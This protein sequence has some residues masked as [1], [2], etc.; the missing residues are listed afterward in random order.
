MKTLGL[1]LGSNSLG[2]AVLEDTTGD[3]LDKGVVIFPDGIDP[4]NDNGPLTTPAAQRR[5]VRQARR[6]KFR[7]KMRKWNLL[8]LLIANKMCPL[9]LAELEDWIHNGKYPL[10]NRAFIKWLAATDT[11]NP[12]CDRNAAVEGIVAPFTLGR[13]LYHICQRRGFKSSRKDAAATDEGDDE[14]SK[15]KKEDTSDLGKVKSSIQNLSAAIEKSHAK[16]LG[17]YFYRLIESQKGQLA[18]DRVRGHYT[19]RIE[20]YE[21]EFA[22]IMEV[23]NIPSDLRD[24]LHAAIFW[25]RPLRSQKNL[26][27]HCPLE[28]KCARAPIGHPLVEEFR[29]W[30]FINNLSFDDA[31]GNK[32]ELTLADKQKVSNTFMKASSTFKFGDISKAFKSDPRFKNE[33]YHFHYYDDREVLPSCS[34]RHNLARHFGEVEYDENLVFN[35]LMFFEDDEKLVA[36]LLKHHTGLS[37]AQARKIIKI[38]PR[39]GYASYSLK[40]IR[41]I[42]PFLRKGYELSFAKFLAKLPRLIPDFAAHE[43]SI[44]DNLNVIHN[45]YTNDK[46][47]L[48]QSPTKPNE[49]LIPLYDRYQDYF[50]TA[51]GLDAKQ[52]HKLYL[53][54]DKTYAHNA[55]RIPKVK[56]GMIRNPLVQRSMTTLRRLVNYLRDHGIID[57]TTAINI[58]LARDVNNSSTR[59]GWQMWQKD[60]QALRDKGRAEIAAH[61]IAITEDAIDRYVLWEEQNKLCIYTGQYIDL[62]NLLRGIGGFDVEHTI[63]RSRLGDDSLAN[64]TICDADYNRNIKGNKVPRACPNWDEPLKPY[65]GTIE[66]NLKVFI[67]KRDAA[68]DKFLAAKKKAKAQTDPTKRSSANAVAI[69]HRFELDYWQDKISRF[70]MTDEKLANNKSAAGFKNRQLVDTGIMC[71]HAVELLKSVYAKVHSVNGA[72]T[73]FARKAWD[74]QEEDAAKD[75]S[76]HT[77]HAKDAMVIAALNS[78]RFNAICAALKDDGQNY[79]R[80]CD[81]CPTPWPNFAERVRRATNEILVKH[82]LRQ[83]TLKQSTKC[84]SLAK[85]HPPK[86]N[87]NGPRI[88]DVR[89]RGD[90]VRGQLHKDTFYGCIQKPGETKTVFVVRKPLIGLKPAD[91]RKLAKIIVDPAIQKIVLARL[92]E[93][94]ANGAKVINRGDICMPSGVPINKVR[95]IANTTNPMKLRDHAMASD[96]DYKTPYYV[97]AAE[98]S[99][100]RLAV[101]NVDGKLSVKPD[102][103]LIWAQNHKKPDYVPFDKQPGFIGYIMPGSMALTYE[104][105]PDELKALP[106]KDL[107]KR[108]Y[109]VVKFRSDGPITFRLHTEARASTVLGEALVAMGKHKA[110]ESKIDY[111]NPHELLLVG[112]G[113]YLNHMLF[114]GIDFKMNLDG[115]IK[116]NT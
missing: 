18:K 1:D 34:V 76:E 100:F 21:K 49:K 42:L 112:P 45:E 24:K 106:P 44:I 35:A 67:T 8:K 58:E 39:E 16:T 102:N 30:S 19:G 37:E 105:S 108:L 60:R 25:Q 70:E 75:R 110:G 59:K 91:V 47:R 94:E 4:T 74:I 50:L 115:S 29:M 82:V 27:G 107:R 28:H 79:G 88:K 77:H 9:T 56:L 89:S 41:N 26:V 69:R 113:T 92:D 111:K 86:N 10:A 12:Y 65:T 51:F 71:S 93:L 63:P 20:H 96:K 98:G 72:A 22:T 84:N 15:K 17:Q 5:L 48:A 43:E 3:I 99:N 38:H 23:Q 2:W 114:E 104:N 40:A 33:G 13:A 54:G 7:R 95:I 80:P 81:V 97:T 101:F 73:S 36:W 14:N 46:A 90:T 52:F 32:V 109:K 78:A 55:T 31:N 11:S 57:E 87:P 83:T 62:D 61:G 6:M 53:G 66:Q 103:S 68:K 64:K 116:F 85:S